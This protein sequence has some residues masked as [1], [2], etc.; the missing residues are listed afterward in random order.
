MSNASSFARHIV[1]DGLPNNVTPDKRDTFERHCHRRFSELLGHSQFNLQLLVD[2]KTALVTGA[3]ISCSTEEVAEAA[4]AKLNRFPLTK[5]AILSTYR[6]SSLQNARE[7]DDEYVPPRLPEEAEGEADFVHNMAEDMDA[8]PQ[9]IIKGGMS[10]D[11]EWYW[12]N[13]ERGEPELYRRPKFSKDD[14]LRNWSEEDRTA[15]KLSDGIICSVVNAA[16]PLPV[17]S[18]YGSM[19]ISQHFPGLRIW[20]GRSMHLL[21]EIVQEVNAFLVSP[22]EKYMVVR[23]SK[24]ISVYN[25][26]TAKKIRTIGNLDLHSDYSWP[27]MRFSADDTLISV[28]KTTHRM[29][30]GTEVPEGHLNIYTAETMK[31]L[32]DSAAGHTFSVP[33]LQKAEW[34]P[35]VDTQMAYVCVLGPNQGWKVV[36]ANIIVKEDGEVEQQVIC[37]RNF[38]V[39]TELD[40]LWHQAGTFLSVKVSSK[41]GTEFFLMHVEERSV[42][43][44]RLVV[45]KGYTPSRFAWQTGGDRF[46]LI[47]EKEGAS[48]GLGE[49]SILQI[50]GISKQ[51]PKVLYEIP[52][53]A[54]RLFWAPQGG[55]LVAANF[56]KSLLHFITLGDKDISDKGK[57]SSITATNA[58]WDP[59][60]RYFAVWVSSVNGESL[61]P[62]YRIYDYTGVEIYKRMITPFSHFAWR[63]LP[64]SLLTN[65]ELKKVDESM[66]MVLHDYEA[67]AAERCKEEL[68]RVQAE[69]KEKETEFIKKM[70]AIAK[71]AESER[72]A[73]QRRD[74]QSRSKW[75][76]FWN[77]RV[78]ALPE[79]K[80]TVHEEVTESR[81]ISRRLVASG[82][83]KAN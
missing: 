81:V 33:G 34:N 15:K 62:Q 60:G 50:L 10:M 30:S 13:W 82:V 54:T 18:T 74:E 65:T 55:R 58:E 71:M 40:M 47:L 38:L 16:R 66:K 3:I 9:F 52:T 41:T 2:Q 20:G 5:S 8:R 76:R 57:L 32:K 6:W 4:L 42:P 28:C 17:W 26:R 24:D 11:C 56:K 64:P 75:V 31:L 72:L 27:L 67:T 69:R 19:V 21:F 36:V 25:L 80:R 78:K 77:T 12:L 29:A 45:K 59:T 48:A 61:A 79:D 68:A 7:Q 14:P 53:G 73:E 22:G 63:P 44:I 1:I 70:Q 83:K 35:I 49:T 37:E 39:A 46:A 51:G 43:V 23:S